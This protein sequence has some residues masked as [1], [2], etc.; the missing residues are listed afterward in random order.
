[1]GKH[2]SDIEKAAFLVHLQYFHQAEAARRVGIHKST[3]ADIKAKA[4]RSIRSR[5]YREGSTAPYI[6]GTG[7]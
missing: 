2:A 4:G 1:M 5:A 6:S 7:Y 3:A